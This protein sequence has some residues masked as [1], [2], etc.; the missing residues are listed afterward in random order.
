MVPHVTSNRSVRFRASSARAFLANQG[1]IMI[2]DRPQFESLEQMAQATAAGLVEAASH[3]AFGLSNDKKFRRM[4]GF[5][6]LSQ[7][8]QDRIF[9]ELI[10]ADIVLLMLV[11][12][13][14]D[15]RVPSEFKNICSN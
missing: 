2:S 10:V 14:P 15:L 8:E 5:N 9:N 12:E 3:Q 7:V 11:L 13:A 4:A 1:L 6:A